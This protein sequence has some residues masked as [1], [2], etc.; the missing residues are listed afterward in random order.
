MK[1]PKNRDS[2]YLVVRTDAKGV[3]P[4]AAFRTMDSADEYSGAC[5]Q[6]FIDR[7]I[8]EY[9]FKTLAVIYYDV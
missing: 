3:V 4:I 7:N 9:D 2:V 8:D 5:E 1:L 6:E